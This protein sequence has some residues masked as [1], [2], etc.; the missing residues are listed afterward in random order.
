[1][2]RFLVNPQIYDNEHLY[3]YLY[4]VS[5]QNHY[6]ALSTFTN[7]ISN[8]ANDKN[9]SNAYAIPK[10]KTMVTMSNMLNISVQQIIQ[11][12]FNRF[13]EIFAPYKDEPQKITLSDGSVITLGDRESIRR[14]CRPIHISAFCPDCLAEAAYLRLHWNLLSST[15]CI[16]HR[17]LLLDRCQNCNSKLHAVDIIECE[18]SNCGSDLR[19]QRAVSVEDDLISVLMQK[20]INGWMGLSAPIDTIPDVTPAILFRVFNG[21]KLNLQLL[22]ENQLRKENI[23]LAI[24]RRGK[25][26]WTQPISKIHDMNIKAIRA[27]LNFPTGL[28]EFWDSIRNQ[29]IK[30]NIS[31]GLG[32]LYWGWIDKRWLGYEYEFLQKAFNEYLVNHEE[33]LTPVIAKTR[34]FADYPELKKRFK[35]ITY[36]AAAKELRTSAIAVERFVENGVLHGIKLKKKRANGLVS[37]SELQYLADMYSSAF[38][39]KTTVKLL[40]ASANVVRMFVKTGALKIIDVPRDSGSKKWMISRLSVYL[41][42]A[43]LAKAGMNTDRAKPGKLVTFT[44]LVT[45]L[46]PWGFD[47]QDILNRI[48]DGTID[49]YFNKP[50]LR[51]FSTMRIPADAAKNIRKEFLENKGWISAKELAKKLGVKYYIINRWV[52]SGLISPEQTFLKTRYFCVEAVNVFE[53]RYMTTKEVSK[54]LGIGILTVQK[55]ARNGRLKPISGRGIDGCHEYRFDRK[56]VELL[57][58][59]NCMT[60]PEYAKYLGISRTQ[61]VE[62]IRKG[63]IQP[64]SGPG[65]DGEH[66]YLIQKPE[67][68]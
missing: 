13:I 5:K 58:G 46:R 65:I 63:L 12:S 43:E 29:N 60:A 15:V 2:P 48:I 40:G 26:N 68:C 56:Q 1:M 21:L 38:D 53:N 36:S 42:Q 45:Q 49:A 6:T 27:L 34:R 16:E 7:V 25:I 32:Q 3:S 47:V 14:N 44:K 31:L 9:F 10:V 54:E 62:R 4:R 59:D 41:L 67:L 64:V 66:H 33:I 55:W 35:Y 19:K 11:H 51:N 61:V 52:K 50:D 22:S 24:D 23:D 20:I 17:K 39:L 18:C 8:Q 28:Y 30:G 57:S 37:N